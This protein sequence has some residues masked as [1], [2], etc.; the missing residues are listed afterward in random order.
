MIALFLQEVQPIMQT[1]HL[2]NWFSQ[3]TI[4]GLDIF[5]I[6][7]PFSALAIGG[8]TLSKIWQNDT[9]L[10]QTALKVL[11]IIRSHLAMLLISILTILSIGILSVVALHMIAE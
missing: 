10:R 8:I 9:E 2:V 5:L 4:L 6:A 11:I 3:H 7:M 1:G